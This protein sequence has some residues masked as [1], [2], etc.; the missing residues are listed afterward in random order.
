MSISSND[1]TATINSGFKYGGGSFQIGFIINTSNNL[2]NYTSNT[3]NNLSELIKNT[4]N[5]TITISNNFNNYTSNVSNFIL[6]NT[7]NTSNTSFVNSNNLFNYSLTNSNNLSDFIKVNSNTSLTNSNNLSDFIKVNSNTSLTNSNNL[8][9]YSLT[10]SNNLSDFIKVNSNTSLTNSN[11][12]SDFIKV[13]SNTSLTNSNNLYNLSL[14]NSNNLANYTFNNSNIFNTRLANLNINTDTITQGSSNRFIVN[15]IYNR[16]ITFTNTLFSSNI[17]TS[18][19]SVIGDTTTLNTTIYQTEQLQV[20]NDTTA[21]AMIVKQVNTNRNVAEFY[22]QN[23]QI[24]LLIN[25][26]GHIGIGTAN[27]ITTLDVRGHINVYGNIYAQYVQ[28][29]SDGTSITIRSKLTGHVNLSSESGNIFFKTNSSNRFIIDSSG[30]IGI[31]TDNPLR[32]LDIFNGE[33]LIRNSNELKNANILF[34]TQSNS[35]A[36]IKTAIIAENLNS[37]N[38]ANLHFCLADD[39]TTQS[40][41]SINFAKMT[42]LN[43]GNIGIGITNPLNKLDVNGNINSSSISI[44][45][46]DIFTTINNNSNNLANYTLTTSNNLINHISYTSNILSTSSSILSSGGT[47]TGQLT[48]STA[49]GNNPITINSS[50]TNA[51]NAINIKNNFTCNAF[52][53]VGGSAYG[54][55]YAN[56]LFFESSSSSIIFNTNGRTSTSVPNMIIN[57]SGNVGI[58]TTN[59]TCLLTI[60]NSVNFKIISLYDNGLTN[61]FQYVG[62][63]ASNGLCFNTFSSGDAF[64]FRVGASTTTANEV[65]RINGNGSVCIGTATATS[66]NTK[67]TISGSSSGYSQPLVNITQSSGIWDGNYALQVS[68]YTNLGGF[69]INGSDTGNSIY[70]TL[71]NSNM[72]FGLNPANTSGNILFTTYGSGGNIIFYTS[73]ENERMIINSSGNVIVN[74]NLGVGNNAPPVK[75]YVAGDIAATGDITAYYSDIRLKDIHSTINNPLDII[76]NLNGFYYTPNELAKSFGIIK[77]KMEIGLSAQDV[78]NVLPELVNIAPFDMSIDENGNIKSKSGD[79]YLTISYERLVPILIEGIKEQNKKISNLE[80]EINEI[81]KIIQ[82]Y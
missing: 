22:Y 51:N 59:P 52:I 71:S 82:N 48:L 35:T 4:N 40:N 57:S 53:G 23:N 30:N 44:N 25:S 69:R 58:G 42:I 55:Y 31:G 10:N 2:I 61:S 46:I 6:I 47:M 65:M 77:N 8:F 19:L 1:L 16:N 29:L 13:N 36:P 11:N 72:G 20:V 38:R 54:G 49:N 9:N 26:S 39:T 43:N 12:L 81:K 24:S 78:Q 62:L 37:W 50:A 3:S 67:L 79:N 80:N 66:S 7:S 27:P 21:T 33:L 64:K 15:D 68:G 17:T 14:T 70:Q 28:P 45:N 76:N 32:K 41:V 73:G 18:N 63:G 56:N 34:G 75:L 74:N 5:D 60:N